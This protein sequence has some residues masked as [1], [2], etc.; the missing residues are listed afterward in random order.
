VA[1]AADEEAGGEPQLTRTLRAP[2]PSIHLT[3]PTA[4]LPLQRPCSSFES[5]RK[6]ALVLCSVKGLATALDQAC[7]VINTFAAPKEGLKEARE[8]L[9]H[10]LSVIRSLDAPSHLLL[11][12]K[13]EGREALNPRSK[14]REQAAEAALR[15]IHEWKREVGLL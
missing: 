6:V 12:V 9:G 4:R 2:A 8:A 13:R 10:H 7:A 1:L 14:R 3:T 15:A 11:T 5:R